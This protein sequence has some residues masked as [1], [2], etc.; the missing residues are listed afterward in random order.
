MRIHILADFQTKLWED[1]FVSH[2]LFW[3]TTSLLVSSFPIW[4]LPVQLNTFDTEMNFDNYYYSWK[5]LC[6]LRLENRTFDQKF[7]DPHRLL[8]L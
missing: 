5:R 2:E 6:V 1:A 7:V 4:L 8:Q 3:N